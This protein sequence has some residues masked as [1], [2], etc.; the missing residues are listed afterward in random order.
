M[1]LDVE[2][3]CDP[4]TG[5]WG[6]SVPALRITGGGAATRTKAEEQV[7]AAILFTLEG[8][9]DGDGQLLPGG[10][11]GHVHITVTPCHVEPR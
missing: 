1:D 3:Y 6:F 7:C 11:L 8:D 2:Y 4:D 10:Q 9:G 5:L